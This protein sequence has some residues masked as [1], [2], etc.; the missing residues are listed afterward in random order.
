VPLPAAIAAIEDL[1]RAHRELLRVV[2]SLR[3]ADWDRYVPYGEW[4]VKDLV[5]HAIG[6]M[7]PSGPGLI[8]A[9]VLT[10]QFIADTSASFDIRIR[11][12][13][14]VEERRRYT[15][16]D[17][18]QLLFEAHDAM[19]EAALRLDDSH[20]AVLDFPVPIGPEYELRVED[21]LWYGYHDR[22]HADD[23]LRALEVDY[24]PQPVESAPE[25]EATFRAMYRYREGLLRAVYSVADGAWGEPSPAAGWTNL[26]LLAHV[27]SNE[28]R[29]HARLRSLFG[30]TPADELAAINDIDAW[31]QRQVESRRGRTVRQLVDEMAAN[32]YQ[33]LRLLA[34]VRAEHLSRPITL[35]DGSGIPVAEYIAMFTGHE[36]AH[37]GQ[38]VSAS[39][40]RRVG[41]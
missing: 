13:S 33:T 12:Q 39:R 11:N 29:A 1:R 40:A 18:R 14:L 22:Q 15:K 5:A 9:G 27:V 7:S 10:P 38:L 35:A 2:D 32:R 25:I 41:R 26:D 37:A 34:R 36:C 4:T 28:L 24:R 16:E 17:L 6:D 20:R 30:E 3:D 21:W 23:I 31:N 19:I 8:L